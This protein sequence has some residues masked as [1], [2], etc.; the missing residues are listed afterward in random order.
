MF[1]ITAQAKY[2]PVGGQSKVG[3]GNHS[4][5]NTQKGM[6]IKF[7][8]AFDALAR[9]RAHFDSI[10]ELADNVAVPALVFAGSEAQDVRAYA[11]AICKTLLAEGK[12]VETK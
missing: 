10:E 9:V 3:F 2:E 6:F 12:I 1:V 7:D 11:R 8:Q 5:E 4:S